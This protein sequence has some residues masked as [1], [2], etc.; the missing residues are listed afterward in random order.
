MKK[1][2]NHIYEENKI[3]IVKYKKTLQ[4]ILNITILNY[5]LLSGKYIILE[6][7]SKGK[8][9]YLFNDSLIYEGEF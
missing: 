3:K 6:E 5:K 4:N 2:F 7:N 1:L 8:E 9:Y